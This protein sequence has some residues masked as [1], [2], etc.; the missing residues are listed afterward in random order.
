MGMGKEIQDVIDL[1][2]SIS[3]KIKSVTVFTWLQAY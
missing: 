3:E 2:P 1:V